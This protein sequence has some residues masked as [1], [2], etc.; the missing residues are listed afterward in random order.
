M[1]TSK[2]LPNADMDQ[3]MEAIRSVAQMMTVYFHELRKGGMSRKEAFE[4]AL[5]QQARIWPTASKDDR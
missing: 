1:D 4:M 5:Q 2:V 3:A